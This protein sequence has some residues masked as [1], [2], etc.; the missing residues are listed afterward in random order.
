MQNIDVKSFR[1]NLILVY[2]IS[3]A[4][5]SLTLWLV[6]S[7]IKYA[8]FVFE[9]FIIIILY[10][11]LQNYDLKF[12]TK[13]IIK[14][15]IPAG[16]FSDISLIIFSSVLILLNIFQIETFIQLPLALTSASFLVGYS[17]L[18]SL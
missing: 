7:E 8:L 16:F 1:N 18:N 14:T 11:I 6:E 12:Y 4:F 13:N 5:S 3:I 15:R 17:L 9:I 2:I 10:F